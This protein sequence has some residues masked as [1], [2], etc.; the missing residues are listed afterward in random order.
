MIPARDFRGGDN[1]MF[2]ERIKKTLLKD[3]KTPLEE[4]FT[5]KRCSQNNSGSSS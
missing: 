2:D 4:A 3:L 1:L 5:E